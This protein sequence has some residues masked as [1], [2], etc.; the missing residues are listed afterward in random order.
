MDYC[1]VYC[2]IRKQSRNLMENTI[3]AL[4]ASYFGADSVTCSYICVFITA[5]VKVQPPSLCHVRKG[6]AALNKFH[7][8][9]RKVA[10]A[11]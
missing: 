8:L 10:A 2:F 9:Q 4:N 1:G 3:N 11:Q 6:E 5:L 7:H